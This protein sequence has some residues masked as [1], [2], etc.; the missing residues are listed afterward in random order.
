MVHDILG[1]WASAG[2]GGLLGLGLVDGPP[3]LGGGR[4]RRTDRDRH[5]PVGGVRP[6]PAD[7]RGSSGF[8]WS[9]TGQLPG[10]QWLGRTRGRC[11]P[12]GTDDVAALV[13][14]ATRSAAGVD[15]LRP[16]IAA[17]ASIP[18]T[19]RGPGRTNTASASTAQTGTPDGIISRS[20][21]AAA[22]WRAP[23]RSYPQGATTTRSAPQPARAAAEIEV[24]AVPMYQAQRPRRRRRP[25]PAPSGR[26]EAGRSTP[27]RPPWTRSAGHG[28]RYPAQP[29]PQAHD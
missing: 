27:P 26:P 20:R 5:R 2:S 6:A 28:G 22:R 3:A 18:S 29:S 9:R 17:R 21:R 13:R 16:Q 19:R 11:S 4:T 24:G 23:A 25:C 7:A 10:T 12:S 8:P 15:E 1:K 14:R